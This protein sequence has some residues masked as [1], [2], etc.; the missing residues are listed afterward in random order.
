[1]DNE[2]P[3]AKAEQNNSAAESTTLSRRRFLQAAGAG[4]LAVSSAAPL[5]TASSSVRAQGKQQVVVRG[6]GGAYQEAM[7]KALYKPFTEATGIEVVVQPATAAQIRAMVE[8]KRVQVDVVDLLDVALLSLDKIGALEPIAYSKMKYTNPND[9][10]PGVRH[11]NMVGNLYFATVMV[12][13]TD[14][15]KSANHPKSWAEFWDVS[16]FPGARTLA[17]QKS[18]AAELEFALLADGVPKDKLYPLDVPRALK[19]LDRIKKDVVKWWDTGAAS[20]Q[21]L[22]RKEAV[23]GAI[24]NGRAQDLIDK[25]APL[26][27]EWNQAKRQVQYWSVIKNSPNAANAQIFIDFALQPKVQAA[28]TRYIAY[29]P[30]NQAAVKLVRPEDA[31]KLPSMPDHFSVG[32]DQ[33][34]QWWSDN[35]STIGEQWQSW[36]L[37]RT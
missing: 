34:A 18:G 33:N 19:S 12:Y 21:L 8:A 2:K 1:M 10:Q 27:I 24:W 7:D 5:L 30:T 29:G 37:R 9:I 36:I 4:A 20:A 13:N 6:L 11:P 23:I 28:L 15:F 32:F 35:L 25:G 14:V 17:D 3:E 26:A 16:K 22:E 31:A